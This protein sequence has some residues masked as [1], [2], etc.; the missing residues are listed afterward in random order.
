M[1]MDATVRTLHISGYQQQAVSYGAN[2]KYLGYAYA[3][4]YSACWKIIPSKLSYVS[5]YLRE[6]I[7]SLVADLWRESEACV[8]KS[9]LIF[10]NDSISCKYHGY[11]NILLSEAQSSSCLSVSAECYSDC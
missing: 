10:V 11:F 4:D 5:A 7:E 9:E 6:F 1:N 2:G 8:G 3:L